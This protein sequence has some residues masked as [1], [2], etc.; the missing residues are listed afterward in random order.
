MCPSPQK[1]P[2]AP[3]NDRYAT[4]LC[5]RRYRLALP[6]LSLP[7]N[8]IMQQV[9]LCLA[10]FTQH[11][12]LAIHLCCYISISSLLMLSSIPVHG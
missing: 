9:L 6:F 7:A 4:A 3:F 2:C 11:D 5:L 10:A 8:E 1:F 12:A